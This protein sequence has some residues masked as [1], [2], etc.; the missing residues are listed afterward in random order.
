MLRFIKT[1]LLFFERD[2]IF[3]KNRSQTACESMLWQ[4]SGIITPTS[5]NSQI[6]SNMCKERI[7][8]QTSFRGTRKFLVCTIRLFPGCI[9]LSVCTIDLLPGC[10]GLYNDIDFYLEFLNQLEALTQ[11]TCYEGFMYNLDCK[12]YCWLIVRR[13]TKPCWCHRKK[14]I[15]LYHFKLTHSPSVV[16]SSRTQVLTPQ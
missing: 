14:K 12:T 4:F 9:G 11:P 2:R 3:L 8:W 1:F 10:I 16:L 5:T 7:M 13:F 15:T 6:M